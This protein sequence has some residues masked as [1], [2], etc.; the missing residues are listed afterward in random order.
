MIKLLSAV[1]GVRGILTSVGLLTVVF[2]V[3]KFI[4]IPVEVKQAKK[5]YIL[6][7]DT[8]TR[9]N[10][11]L[12]IEYIKKAKAY[13]ELDSLYNE[14]KTDVKLQKDLVGQLQ[15][16]YR[17]EVNLN[18]A[19]KLSIANLQ[20]GVRIDLVTKTKGFFGGLKDSTYVKGWKY[21]EP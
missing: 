3:Y 8:L 12:N 4:V 14:V 18:K 19:N 20:K 7:V 15:V 2:L 1:G 16:K 11:T 6:A 5:P 21:G 10:K 17:D 9:Q 13:K